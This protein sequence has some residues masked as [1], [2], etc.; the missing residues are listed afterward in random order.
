MLNENSFDF[1]ALNH[2]RENSKLNQICPEIFP[3][4][5]KGQ[6]KAY[7]E[8]YEQF[9]GKVTQA[10]TN[11]RFLVRPKL[12]QVTRQDFDIEKLIKDGQKGLSEDEI[13]KI[14]EKI[15]EIQPQIA[16]ILSENAS[17]PDYPK[18]TFL[19]TGS[20]MPGKYRNASSILVELEKDKF[21]I[22]DCGEGT[23]LQLYRLFGAEKSEFILKNLRAIYIS[24][25]HADHHLGLIHL[26][27]KREKAFENQQEIID[28]MYILAPA[29]ISNYLSIYHTRFQPILTDMVHIRN[30]NLLSK[31]LPGEN[32][33]ESKADSY[34]DVFQYIG[35]KSLKTCRV[36]HC[37]SAFGVALVNH[38]G[39]KI[40]YSGDTRPCQ[41][42]ID[43]GLEDQ[44]TDLLIHEAT[45][46]IVHKPRGQKKGVNRP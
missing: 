6:E 39:Y 31:D 19:G 4:F 5:L 9:K 14:H 16:Q 29:R 25:L 40:V 34:E 2:L 26:I 41:H 20:A 38:Q 24:H 8:K 23:V 32:L 12:G 21:M 43:L 36:W 30:E 3:K 18:V 11:L 45:L 28:K 33:Y 17:E 42:L 37:P 35:L 27:L 22:M 10:E 46:G 1:A 44:E 7:E 13:G 15:A